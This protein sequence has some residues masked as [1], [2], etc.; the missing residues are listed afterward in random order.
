VVTDLVG[1]FVALDASDVKAALTTG[2]GTETDLFILG[3][4][5]KG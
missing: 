1:R 2:G 5:P 3:P 4:P